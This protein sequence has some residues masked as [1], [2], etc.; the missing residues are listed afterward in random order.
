MEWGKQL[1][2]MWKKIGIAVA[3]WFVMKYLTPLVIP[4]LIA[5]AIVYWC[6]PLLRFLKK[7]FRIPE[8][9]SMAVLL[10]GAAGVLALAGILAGKNLQIQ[11]R[12]LCIYWSY[13]DRAGQMFMG[14][15]ERMGEILQ[16]DGK[17]IQEFVEARMAHIENPSW[18]RLLP[19]IFDGS[20]QA[21]V[22]MGSFLTG[23]F[24]TGIATVLLAA[25]YEKIREMG[26]RW[27]FYEKTAEVLRG[28]SGAIGR[29]VRAQ[30]RIMILVMLICTIGIW[31]SGASKSPLAAGISTGLLDALPVFGTGTVL[32]P[33]ILILVIGQRRYRAAA[34]LALTY[35]LCTLTRE[36]LE[37]RLVGAHLKILPV[38][39]LLSVYVGVKIYGAGGIVL[40]PL[41]VVVIQELWK[42][43][44]VKQKD[45]ENYDS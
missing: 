6:R 28:I 2:P 18:E 31:L 3:V 35:G 40:G 22:G 25:D 5:G 38:V 42:R 19:D 1:G 9:V 17:K 45:S 7:R 15:C 41:S 24:V 30:C 14:C 26:Q 36:L 39:V 29:Y 27:S 16:V 12:R 13:P 21:V 23:V 44:D 34:V 11:I 4:F 10:G 33:W 32:V 37:P 20:R 8:G 43:V